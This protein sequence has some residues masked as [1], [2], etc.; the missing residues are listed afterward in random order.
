LPSYNLAASLAFRG[1]KFR[2]SEIA[3]LSAV[4]LE[5]LRSNDFCRLSVAIGMIGKNLIVEMAG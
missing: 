2:P 1:N 4:H 5:S 3:F